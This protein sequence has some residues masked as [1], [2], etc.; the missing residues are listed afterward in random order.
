[1]TSVKTLIEIVPYDQRWPA[2]FR[3]IGAEAYYDVKDPVCDIIIAAAELWA[4][5]TSYTPGPS[6][7]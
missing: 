5:E 7:L 3:R 2:E 4:V 1:V 6:D